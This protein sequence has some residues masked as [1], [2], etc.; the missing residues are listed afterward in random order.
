MA[1]TD[2]QRADL[3]HAYAV[4]KRTNALH[5]L[6]TGRGDVRERVKACVLSALTRLDG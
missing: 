3:E 6:V 2:Q 1:L 4:E 5:L